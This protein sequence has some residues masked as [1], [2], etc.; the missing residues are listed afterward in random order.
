[1]KAFLQRLLKF[2]LVFLT[3]WLLVLLTSL[4]IARR[5]TGLVT[6]TG[7]KLS[8]PI[9][10]LGNS[11][12][13]CAFNDSLLGGRFANVAISAEPLFY[14]AIKAQTA[15]NMVGCD[16]M[17]ID[18][19][20]NAFKTIDWVLDDIRCHEV[21]T[22]YFSRMSLQQHLFLLKNN[23]PK[24]LK[25]WASVNPVCLI[26]EYRKTDGQFRALHKTIN[27]DSATAADRRN[28]AKR[29]LYT[30]ELQLQNPGAL[31]RL[32]HDNPGTFFIITRAP[33]HPAY[34]MGYE[35]EF[36]RY[37]DIIASMPNA[38][39]KDFHAGHTLTDADFADTEHLNARGADKFTR[40]FGHWYHET[41]R[42]ARP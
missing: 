39:F 17:V 6:G 12:P 33:M 42:P 23:F 24:A 7:K 31:V 37:T 9:L 22:R 35:Q 38:V 40:I 41:F 4:V 34:R 36:D 11:H 20:N 19:S 15:I 30:P 5:Q 32:I 21:Y 16:T 2:L 14:T 28:D 8:K 3:L 10:I 26:E 18:F 13:E 29:K 1:M 27:V 25:V